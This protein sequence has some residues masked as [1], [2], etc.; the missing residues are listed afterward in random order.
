MFGKKTEIKLGDVAR[1]TISGFEGVVI[2]RTEWL[3]GCARWCLQPQKLHDGKPIEGHWFDEPQVERV[4]ADAVLEIQ[5]T[6]GPRS[7]P[8]R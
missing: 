3:N 7:D 2:G 6:G 4:K 1:D 8:K 5:K